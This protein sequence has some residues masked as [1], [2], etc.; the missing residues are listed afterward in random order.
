VLAVHLDI[1]DIVLEDGGDVDLKGERRR[2]KKLATGYLV[3]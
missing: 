1:G 3:K 2:E